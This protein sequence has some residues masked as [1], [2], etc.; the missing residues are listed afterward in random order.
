MRKKKYNKYSKN[1]DGTMTIE[2]DGS[3]PLV[4]DF[5]DALKLKPFTVRVVKTNGYKYPAITENI[6]K[7]DGGYITK[8][9][10]VGKFI[11]QGFGIVKYLDKNPFNCRRTNLKVY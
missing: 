3:V 9:T 1:E 2:I 11:S 7:E 5:M 4:L 6:K 10:L 8:H